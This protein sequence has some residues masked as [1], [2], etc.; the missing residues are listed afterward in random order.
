MWSWLSAAGPANFI[1]CR[2]SSRQGWDGQDGMVL[3]ERHGGVCNLQSMLVSSLLDTL[4]HSENTHNYLRNDADGPDNFL[5]NH[6]ACHHHTALRG[7]RRPC[8][9]LHGGT[10]ARLH[11]KLCGPGWVTNQDRNLGRR[12]FAPNP[13]AVPCTGCISYYSLRWRSTEFS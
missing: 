5:W 3:R 7:W 13:S 2:T 10:D 8:R 4:L 6:A 11:L 9:R 1:A 12:S